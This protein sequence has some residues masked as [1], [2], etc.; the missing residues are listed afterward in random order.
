MKDKIIIG[1]ISFIVILGIL[2]VAYIFLNKPE[3]YSQVT[4]ISATD[5]TKWANSKKNVLVIYSDF[6]CPACKL[7]NETLNQFE[8]TKS[9]NFALTKKITL[10]FRHF[11][12]HE[13]SFPIAYVVE[14]A[15]RQ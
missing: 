12:I 6:L 4:K 10:V 11:P 7:F 9:A 3:D 13:Q 2:T 15:G 14:A 1:L 5:R 8:S